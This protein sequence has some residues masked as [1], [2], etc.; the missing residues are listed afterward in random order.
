MEMVEAYP[1][2]WPQG[3][4]RTPEDKRGWARFN[5]RKHTSYGVHGSRITM[6]TALS[7][8]QGECD[9]LGAV[10]IVLSSNLKT[11]LDG[12][13]YSQQGKVE[14]PGV[15]LYFELDGV[16]QCIPCDKWDRPE[17]NVRA[18]AKTIEALRGIERWGAKE[19]VNAAFRGFKALPEPDVT[20]MTPQYFADCED[21]QQ[22]KER[23]RL[24][25]K[26]LHPDRGGNSEEFG[27]MERQYKIFKEAR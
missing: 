5:E 1:L 2:S 21:A 18:I 9:R 14:D 11:R 25:A 23:H 16:E 15:A 20:V 12:L 26:E 6:S 17:D 4:P 7:H 24:L 3:W 13:P 10:D 8:L 22:A 27:E 19:M